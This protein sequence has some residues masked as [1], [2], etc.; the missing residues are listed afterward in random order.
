MTLS[1]DQN[2]HVTINN[3]IVGRVKAL[4]HAGQ[5]QNLT[6]HFTQD[7]MKTVFYRFNKYPPKPN[8]QTMFI[9]NMPVYKLNNDNVSSSLNPDLEAAIVEKL[10]YAKDRIT[11]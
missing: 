9:L 1:I 2:D 3:K 8:E 7:I 4:T 5:E 11:S 6:G 10:N